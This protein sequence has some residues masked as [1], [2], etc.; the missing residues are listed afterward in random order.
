MLESNPS[1][2]TGDGATGGQSQPSSAL[3]LSCCIVWKAINSHPHSEIPLQLTYSSEDSH[4]LNAT[5]VSMVYALPFHSKAIVF[6]SG[7]HATGPTPTMSNGLI[8]EPSSV[9]MI[10]SV[11]SATFGPPLNAT[12]VPSEDQEG[13]WCTPPSISK[14]D[15]PETKSSS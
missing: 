9:R 14:R 15:S 3:R 11:C 12:I 6:P 8:V 13:N 2:D 7:D 5:A 10:T 1:A 4:S